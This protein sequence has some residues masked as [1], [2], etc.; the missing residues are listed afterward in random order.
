MIIGISGKSGSGKSTLAEAIATKLDAELICFDKISHM[1]I[2]EESFKKLVREKVSTEVFDDNGNIIRKKLGDV[3]F[4]NN[5]KLKL[6][7]SFSE[8]LMNQIID[9]KINES[10]KSYIVLEYALLPL[11]KQF[12]F[13]NFKILVT[14]ND[15]IRFERI[16]NRDGISE[17]YFKKREA[18]SISYS[19]EQ[20]DIVVEN[21]SNE[22][23][24]VENII[25]LIKNKEKSC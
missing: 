25:N 21:N 20:F 8:N 3:V 5:E 19:K 7:N 11:M 1:T 16:T 15:A 6:I 14:A 23:F 17:E 22:E 4:S 13:C 10:K 18:N 24:S 9:K 2:E 12:N